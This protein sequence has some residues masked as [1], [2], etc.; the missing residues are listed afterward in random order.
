MKTYKKLGV[1]A[2]A[3]IGLLSCEKPEQDNPTPPNP[4]TPKIEIPA[5]SQS[6]F[7]QG[8][9]M[10]AGTSAQSQ[11]VKFSTTA[12]WSTE[13]T[14][15][16]ASA[17]LSVQPTSGNAGAVTMTVSAQA[18]TGTKDREAT[19]TIKCGTVTM[20]FTVKQA[21]IS[22]VEV[23]EV[24]LDKAEL[25]LAEGQEA[26]LTATVKPDNATDK[27]V[28][29]STSDSAV[30]TVTDGKVKA[31]KAGTATITAKAGEK[32]A[33][34]KVTVTTAVIPVES[35]T[36]DKPSATLKVGE[37]V[38]LTATVKPDDA[39]DKT[40]TWTSSDASVATV[41]NGVVTA[42]KV[43]TATITAKAGEKSAT[44][45][46]TVEPTPVTGITLDNATVTLKEGQEIQLTATVAPVDATDK[47]VTWSSNKTDVATV[48]NT[49]KVKAI[50]EGVATI[51]A[52]AGN[53]EATCV[54]TVSKNVI[55]VTS[56]SLDKPSA[57]LKVGET[58]TLTATVKPDDATDKTV[59]WTTSDASVATVSNGVVTAK[60]VG[61]ATITA[62]AGDKEATCAITVVATPVTSVTLDRTSASLKA[63]ETVTLTATVKP[64]DATDKT[65]TWSTSDASVAT[66]DN[67]VVTAVKIGTATITAKA[68][69]KEATCAVTVTATAS[70]G[71]EGIYE[72]DW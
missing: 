52:K 59:T 19:V 69:D 28:T 25:G 14:D 62:K 72:E 4:A 51:T 18:N 17:W 71:H 60:K 48:S 68:G 38:T 53:K 23:T 46:I 56:V 7:S 67:G 44:C 57:S 36:L 54:V 11:T 30:A 2:L 21:G 1:F 55:A 12:A 65:V 29:W 8:I 50:K 64:D 37:T 24:T 43:G 10:D 26:E 61:S 32:T 41:D 70:G 34:C 27:T 40:V 66:V 16:K 45:A 9:S 39:T 42:K 63:G 47:T 22:N 20:K 58:V 6:V 5:E 15:T 13:V 49:G 31:V 3:L 35:V 33:T